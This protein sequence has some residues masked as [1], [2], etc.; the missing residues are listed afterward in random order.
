M[1]EIVAMVKKKKKK[2]K[3]GVGVKDFKIWI[4][5]KFKS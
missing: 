3:G 1:K 5:E 4:L 2:I